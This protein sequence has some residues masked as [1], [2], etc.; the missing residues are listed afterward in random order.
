V[1]KGLTESSKFK[2]DSS[3]CGKKKDNAENAEGAEV[4]RGRGEG[5]S[6]SVGLRVDRRVGSRWFTIY[7]STGMVTL[8]IVTY[9]V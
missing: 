3:K 7:L 5:E 1:V 2:V 8:S 9:M 6:P 4:R